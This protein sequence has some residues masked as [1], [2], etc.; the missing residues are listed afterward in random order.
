VFHY[1]V[2]E[3]AWMRYKNSKTVNWDSRGNA[4]EAAYRCGNLT[5]TSNV[6]GCLTLV[7]I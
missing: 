1:T 4:S 7:H 2:R 3:F 5:A 6:E